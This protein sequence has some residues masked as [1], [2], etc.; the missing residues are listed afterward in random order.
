MPEDVAAIASRVSTNAQLQTLGGAGKGIAW[1][2]V[3]GGEC[4]RT[5]VNGARKSDCS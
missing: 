3:L 1:R 5:S 2:D 4:A